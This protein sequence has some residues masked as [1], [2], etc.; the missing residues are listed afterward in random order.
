MFED[1]IN[2]L[3]AMGLPYIENEDGSL[4]IDIESADKTD[5]VNVISF[6]NNNGLE[7]TIDATTIVVMSLGAVE[8]VEE[9]AGLEDAAMGEDILAGMM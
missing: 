6:L 9:E 2:E 7:Y 4:T 8:P 1:A 5:V 3:D